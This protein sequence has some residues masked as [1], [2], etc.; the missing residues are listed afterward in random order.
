M[1]PLTDS[2]PAS[3]AL[4]DDDSEGSAQ[5]DALQL[6]AAGLD[7]V[8]H[9]AA[10]AAAALDSAAGAELS[11]DDKLLLYGLYKQAS[12][13]RQNLEPYQRHSAAASG[14]LAGAGCDRLGCHD[15]D[16]DA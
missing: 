15:A 12:K 14:A 6:D 1:A 11:Q 4:R 3:H 7:A 2:G 5:Q 9:A 13:S 8:F 16:S 10:D